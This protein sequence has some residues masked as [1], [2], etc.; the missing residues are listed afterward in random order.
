[1]SRFVDEEIEKGEWKVPNSP[2]NRGALLKQLKDHCRETLR[3][4]IE[5]MHMEIRRLGSYPPRAKQ[6]QRRS[7]IIY[8]RM[9]LINLDE[10]LHYAFGKFGDEIF[11]RI[12]QHKVEEPE[13]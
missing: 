1:M 13:S 12:Q 4:R 2:Q 8:K 3:A 7:D 6:Q 11:N 9:C 5:H 10:N